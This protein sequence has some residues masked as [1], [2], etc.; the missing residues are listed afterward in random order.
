MQTDLPRRRRALMEQP[1]M[2]KWFYKTMGEAFGPFSPS[3][4]KQLVLE[5]TI[6]SETLIRREDSDRW[7]AAEMLPGFSA[8]VAT[9]CSPRPPDSSVGGK[10]L[11]DRNHSINMVRT[12]QDGVTTTGNDQPDWPSESVP[13]HQDPLV[14]AATALVS[15]VAFF[16]VQPFWRAAT[17]TP[18]ATSPTV[19]SSKASDYAS[20][21]QRLQFEIEQLQIDRARLEEE[22]RRQVEKMRRQDGINR[23]KWIIRLIEQIRQ[24]SHQ[25]QM[26]RAELDATYNK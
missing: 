10:H 19:S 1:T 4:I 18:I 5:G 3:E 7:V 26:K 21:R 25:I 22:A 24:V 12:V 15:C 20:H 6:A 2:T 14:W 23:D 16:C 8:V 11:E 17:T 13:G 9:K